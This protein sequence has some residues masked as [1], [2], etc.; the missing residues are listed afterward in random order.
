MCI[1]LKWIWSILTFVYKDGHMIKIRPNFYLTYQKYSGKIL[2]KNKNLVHYG[3]IPNQREKICKTN[4]FPHFPLFSIVLYLSCKLKF[5]TNSPGILGLSFISNP[6]I[7][8][9]SCCCLS[10]SS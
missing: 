10:P 9:F 4:P 1:N 2:E 5:E 3:K 6:I 8:S 7:L